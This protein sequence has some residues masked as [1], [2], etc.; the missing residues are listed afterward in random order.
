M[1]EQFKIYTPKPASITEDFIFQNKSFKPDCAGS[2]FLHSK[3]RVVLK[4]RK[5]C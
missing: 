2:I 4:Q 5:K 3:R 1:Y